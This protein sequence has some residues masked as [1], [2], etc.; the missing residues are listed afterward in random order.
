MFGEHK[1]IVRVACLP[2]KPILPY[3]IHN[4]HVC[5]KKIEQIIH[6]KARATEAAAGWQRCIACKCMSK[7]VFVLT[8]PPGIARDTYGGPHKIHM[9]LNVT[10]IPKMAYPLAGAL[11]S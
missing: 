3:S 2:C 7:L 10:V 9:E 5:C 11:I 1:C 6:D 8:S 4:K